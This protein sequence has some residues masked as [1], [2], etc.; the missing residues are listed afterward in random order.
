VSGR[1]LAVA[2][3]CLSAFSSAHAAGQFI[4][5]IRISR[6]G[7]EATVTI[8]LACPMRFQSDFATR[9]GV[10]LEIRVAPL[11]DCRPL[12]IGA[13]FASERTRPT[14]GRLAHLLEVQY[15][16]LGLG[17][18]L[19]ML[20]FDRA[21]EYRVTQGGG[22][23]S[24][25]LT[26]QL[27]P[28]SVPA[29][30]VV[31]PT[32]PT[33]P[34]R[35]APMNERSRPDDDRAPLRSRVL[36][37]SAVG[38]YMI[39]L[40]S[41]REPADARI[42]NDIGSSPGKFVYLSQ[43]DVDG[44]SWYR[45][46]LGF[47][48]SEDEARVE[49]NALHD[50]FPR[51]WIG[52]AEAREVESA[53]DYRIETGG[54]FSAASLAESDI[55]AAPSE[56]GIAS[57]SLDDERVAALMD[58]GRAALLA[59]DFDNAI[60]VYT[61]VLRTPGPHRAEAREF[62]GVAREKNGQH[63]HAR[64]E[65]RA[66]LD[67]FDFAPDAQRVRQRLN[68]LVTVTATPRAPLRDR[69]NLDEGRWDFGSGISQYYRR[70][71]YQGDENQDE[72]VTF[73]ALLSDIDLSFR[74]SG[75]RLDLAGRMAV[76]QLYDLMDEERSRPADQDRVSYAYMDVDAVEGDWS[77][78]M[79]RQSLHNW[80]VLGRF[81]GAHFAYDWGGKRTL[82]YM[83]GYPVESTRNSVR[84]DREFQAV[85]IEFQ[86]VIGGWDFG[87]YFNHQTLGGIN[88]RQA[89]GLEARYL[90]DRRS[91]TGMFDFDINYEELNAALVLGTW[92]FPNR[93]TVSALFD[94]RMSPFL[95]TRNALIGQPITTV[96]E[97]LL[98]WTVE[99]I[100][101]LALD[102]T[103]R[104][105]TTTIGIAKPIGERFHLNADITTTEI[106]ATVASAGVAAMPATG[107]QTY[108]SA[109]LVGSGLFGGGDVSIVNLRQGTAETF[110]ISQVTLDARFPVGRRIRLNPRIRYAVRDGLV[111]GRTR[112]TASASFRL[113][114]NLR[115]H[116][117]LELEFGT[118]AI[119]RVDANQMQ[120]STGSFINLGYRAD[121]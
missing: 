87:T 24:L 76:S 51:A 119:T 68:G 3:L 69:E 70:H 50:Q 16:S 96:E 42:V 20:Y 118:D 112:E 74:R 105:V 43:A 63:A 72:I 102:R 39:N 103:S 67:E 114:L 83:T 111:D 26:V 107:K 104:S 66:Y 71:T 57:E 27:D 13:G 93:I 113:L 4:E 61:R 36:E 11:E 14:G 82:H 121:F 92:R 53:A 62:L 10:L 47:Y 1:A 109:S 106:D 44:E 116:Y 38:D 75:D 19:I 58:E 60:R 7:D 79:G 18:N 6:S 108:Y 46:R 30:E 91:V 97:L 8:D 34:L 94:M 110:E 9:D 35:A 100:E 99:E 15:E 55:S 25:N 29:S 80:G 89:V 120:D 78:R 117:R 31:M 98:V 52:R 88:D 12:G 77:L 84:T 95:T 33:E 54:V 49:L 65:Y 22:L 90:D 56:L 37:P 101:R 17:D 59:Q 48:A 40:Q 32:G 2:G 64:A 28:S 5:D 41:T 115:N 81:D 85:G 23:R 73:S 86:D 21:V 45:L